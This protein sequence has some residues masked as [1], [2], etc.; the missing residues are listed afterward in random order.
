MFRSSQICKEVETPYV[1][2]Y[3]ARRARPLQLVV[4]CTDNTSQG[5]LPER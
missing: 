2:D 1:K 3:A 5:Y 4:L